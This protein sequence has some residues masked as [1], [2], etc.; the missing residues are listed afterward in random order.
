MTKPLEK[1]VVVL[2]KTPLEELI[3]RFNTL[4]Q[5]RFYIEH[6]GES[7]DEY[8][9]AHAI[10][11]ESRMHLMN[12]LPGGVR[13]QVIERA[14]LP[15]YQFGPGDLV[16]TLGPDG[17]VVNVAKY[18]KGQT[19]VAFNADPARNDGVLTPFVVASAST[20]LQAATRRLLPVRQI[21]MAQAV[22]QDN[23]RLLAVNDLFIGM[24]SHA[25]ARYRLKWKEREEPQ[26]SSGLI[27]STGAGSTGW[28][29]SII[30][31]AM[32]I[33]VSQKYEVP[34]TAYRFQP[35]LDQLAFCV[36]EPFES[37][38]S[39][40]GI[41][42]DAIGPGQALE[43]TSQMPQNGVIFSDGIENDFLSFNA[44]MTARIG[45]AEEK[46]NLAGSV[47]W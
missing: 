7:F 25:S 11:D 10:Y 6:L 42:A 1:I 16:V 31:G 37:R 15:M 40:I 19:L 18:L 2:K 33:S 46:L 30:S 32:R 26:I 3:E 39:R 23:Q 47:G 43:I 24:N 12:A 14:T 22:L 13:V 27:V 29:R 45:I 35:E 4:D 5:A 28:R 17:L 9:E 8:Q 36:R 20:V 38:V 21:T 44:G 41:V 34:Q